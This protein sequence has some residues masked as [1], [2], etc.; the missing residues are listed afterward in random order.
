MSSERDII[1]EGSYHSDSEASCSDYEGPKTSIR[2]AP[3]RAKSLFDILCG[4]GDDASS[5][6]DAQADLFRQS[7]TFL[8]FAQK[9]IPTL[10]PIS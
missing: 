9:P 7:P 4:G 6:R 3:K 8:N 5:D 2:K 10:Q 1:N